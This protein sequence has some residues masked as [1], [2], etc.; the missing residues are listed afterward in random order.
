MI[1]DTD[2]PEEHAVLLVPGW[3][4]QVTRKLH[5]R[6]DCRAVQYHSE[7]MTPVLCRFDDANE[8]RR[9]LLDS[10][11]LCRYCFPTSLGFADDD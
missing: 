7:K 5:I 10:D 2:Y 9:V 8:V 4:H 1:E 6:R 3:R 11:E